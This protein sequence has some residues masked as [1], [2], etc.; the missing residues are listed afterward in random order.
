MIYYLRI[1]HLISQRTPDLTNAVQNYLK[2]IHFDPKDS[3][4]LAIDCIFKLHPLDY[5]SYRMGDPNKKSE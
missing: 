1:T 2:K 3:K 4:L 5:T